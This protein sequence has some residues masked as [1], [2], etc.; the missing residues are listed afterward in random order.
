M[1]SVLKISVFENVQYWE[2]TEADE[3][4]VMQTGKVFG[5]SS[6]AAT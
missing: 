2:Q 4:R 5:L 3:E 6:L 1:S